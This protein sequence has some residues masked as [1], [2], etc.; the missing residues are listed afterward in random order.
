LTLRA[1]GTFRDAIG[2]QVDL[3][4]TQD[5]DKEREEEHNRSGIPATE[6][7]EKSTLNDVESHHEKTMKRKRR[8]KFLLGEAIIIN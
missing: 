6:K 5:K 2:P 8:A 4:L 1:T 7:R 3:T